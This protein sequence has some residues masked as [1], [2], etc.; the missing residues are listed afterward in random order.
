MGAGRSPGRGAWTPR[1]RC[2]RRRPTSARP[3]GRCPR[4][5]VGVC[6]RHRLRRPRRRPGRRCG[7][8]LSGSSRCGLRRRYRG[9]C[10]ATRRLLARNRVR[11]PPRR[12][13]STVVCRSSGLPGR[14]QHSRP[15]GS[16]RHRQHRGRCPQ[17]DS[18]GPVE[19]RAIAGELRSQHS[20][21]RC[22][23]RLDHGDPVA[24]G[25]RSGRDFGAEEAGA[26]DQNGLVG[27]VQRRVESYG[28]LERTDVVDDRPPVR[29]SQSPRACAR[30]D[31]QSVE[32]QASAGVE[33]NLAS[34]DVE[35]GH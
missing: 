29:R 11:R 23:R 13:G 6:A 15:N 20:Q 26:D 28:V 4:P 16:G 7:R 22:L 8:R 19:S 25:S 24:A 31:R 35:A 14:R 27:S 17:V 32:P 33:T 30:R 12:H 34:R 5:V 18:A 21:H 9:S 2:G 3:S 10:R 1:S